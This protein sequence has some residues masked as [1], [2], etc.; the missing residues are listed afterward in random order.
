MICCN[1]A[2][3]W[4]LLLL[5]LLQIVSS[6][7]LCL[8]RS[9]TYLTVHAN[10]FS[11]SPSY[12]NKNTVIRWYPNENWTTLTL[13]LVYTIRF[14]VSTLVSS[15]IVYSSRLSHEM[16][17]TRISCLK[18]PSVCYSNLRYLYSSCHTALIG[19]NS[20]LKS[21]NLNDMQTVF[22][23]VFHIQIET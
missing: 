22:I 20:N 10:Y 7:S 9:M 23:F 16:M 21:A 17:F 14:E 15:V 13:L 4:I 11:L 1:C 8:N 2:L 12:K 3:N 19:F 18:F 5:N 6:V